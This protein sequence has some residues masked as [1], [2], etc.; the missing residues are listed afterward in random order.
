[1]FIRVTECFITVLLYY[2]IL[3]LIVI[4]YYTHITHNAH[5]YIFSKAPQKI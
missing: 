1:M 5:I 4:T 3:N 2:Y